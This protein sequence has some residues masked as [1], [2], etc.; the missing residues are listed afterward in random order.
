MRF[1]EKSKE[2][3]WRTIEWSFVMGCLSWLF[4][5]MW[6]DSPY[7]RNRRPASRKW[8]RPSSQSRAEGD[9]SRP[10]AGSDEPRNVGQPG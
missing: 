5:R 7:D 8:F 3:M 4:V 1:M 6:T 9:R 10:P 2:A